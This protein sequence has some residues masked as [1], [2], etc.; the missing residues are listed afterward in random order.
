MHQVFAEAVLEKGS[1]I[2]EP[3]TALVVPFGVLPVCVPNLN[4]DKPAEAKYSKMMVMPLYDEAEAKAAPAQVKSN[5]KLHID[6][7]L[8]SQKETKTWSSLHAQINTWAK[9]WAS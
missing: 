1:G 5:V 2:L 3:K 8:A 6:H 4:V 7:I 9:T